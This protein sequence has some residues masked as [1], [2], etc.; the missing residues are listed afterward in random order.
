MS[1][2]PPHPDPV[3][4]GLQA[5]AFSIRVLAFQIGRAHASTEIL[6]SLGRIETGI[7]KLLESGGSPMDQAAIDALAARLHSETAKLKSALE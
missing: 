2:K 3:A 6:A 5:I 7:Q 4:E 1:P